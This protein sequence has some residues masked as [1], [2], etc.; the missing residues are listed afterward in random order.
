MS[1]FGKGWWLAICFPPSVNFHKRGHWVLVFHLPYF[2]LQGPLYPSQRSVL[3]L[4]EHWKWQKRNDTSEID[5]K[6]DFWKKYFA[7]INMS[8]DLDA[9]A[10]KHGFKMYTISFNMAD[11]SDSFH[12][13]KHD[14]KQITLWTRNTF[15]L[16]LTEY[17]LMHSLM[18][19][20]C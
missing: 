20:P 12:M 11:I 19:L 15:L 8:H 6:N 3:Y 14:T 16:K 10:V 9:S 7:Y 2:C 5:E 17:Q 13:R 4:T 1:P 18:H